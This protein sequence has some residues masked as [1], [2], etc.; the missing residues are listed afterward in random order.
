MEAAKPPPYK[1]SPHGKGGPRQRRSGA[2]V[3]RLLETLFPTLFH[4]ACALSAPSGHLP[5]EGKAD[6]TRMA[7]SHKTFG[8]HPI[9][10]RGEAAT[11]P[12]KFESRD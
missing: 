7:S 4:T 8:H 6:D 3:N 1:P 12:L 10:T 5:L 11:A 2:F 9:C